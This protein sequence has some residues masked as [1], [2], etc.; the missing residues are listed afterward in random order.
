MTAAAGTGH[1]KQLAVKDSNNIDQTAN[2]TFASSATGIATVSTAGLITAV[3]AGTANITASYGGFTAT[4][5][6]TVS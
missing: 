4:C 6:V 1:T 3:A 5:A 2:A